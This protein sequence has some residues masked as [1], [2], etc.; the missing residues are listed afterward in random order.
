MHCVPRSFAKPRDPEL[1]SLRQ[2]W[3]RFRRRSQTWL[4][5][6]PGTSGRY[7]RF[8]A[9][10]MEFPRRRGQS[11]QRPCGVT[12]AW[13]LAVPLLSGKATLAISE[14]QGILLLGQMAAAPKHLKREANAE[15]AQAPP[16]QRRH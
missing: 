10:R 8:I 7:P 13:P 6:W 11:Q 5:Q 2:K 3:L 9:K 16:W 12:P 1:N 15:F 4:A 14:R